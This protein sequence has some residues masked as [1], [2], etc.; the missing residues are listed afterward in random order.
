M[1][2]KFDSFDREGKGYLSRADIIG[3]IEHLGF[4][5]DEDYCTQV[6]Q[7]FSEGKDVME[8]M[9]QEGFPLPVSAWVRR[10]LS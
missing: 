2:K 4:D 6:L 9:H 3:C 8:W 1:K 5:C 7:T 10:A